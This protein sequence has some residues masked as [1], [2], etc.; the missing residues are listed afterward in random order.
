MFKLY[1]V[2]CEGEYYNFGTMKWEENLELDCLAYNQWS[3]E[4]KAIQTEGAQVIVFRCK[5]ERAYVPV[6][7][8]QGGW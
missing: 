1:A 3:A 4:E 8:V 6:S 7:W 2:K 5:R